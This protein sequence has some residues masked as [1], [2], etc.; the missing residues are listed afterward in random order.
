VSV[1]EMM[2]MPS[3]LADTKPGDLHRAQL[4]EDLP[5]QGVAAL[6]DVEL[7]TA[8]HWIEG[9]IHVIRS[10]EL[11]VIAGAPTFEEALTSFLTEIMGFAIYL[12][13]LESLAS[14]E[15]EMFHRLAPRIARVA[16]HVEQLPAAR[17]QSVLGAAVAGVRHRRDTGRRWRRL[18]EQPG[19]AVPSLV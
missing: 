18:S 11:D 4:T 7:S 6:F 15:E 16:Q 3:K 10:L 5:E 17:T 8:E 1:D 14:N 12:G 2:T 13:E 19:S 9:D